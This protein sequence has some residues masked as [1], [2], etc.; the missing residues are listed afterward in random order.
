[1]QLRNTMVKVG[2]HN[3][4]SAI[5]LTCFPFCLK[6]ISEVWHY[7]YRAV[8]CVV[9]SSFRYRVVENIIKQGSKI[10]R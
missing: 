4:N 9:I 1:M 6:F 5:L 2:L 7:H 10:K 3:H 8:Y